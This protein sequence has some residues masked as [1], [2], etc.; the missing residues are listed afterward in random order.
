[1]DTSNP[2]HWLFLAG[3]IISALGQLTRMIEILRREANW[4]KREKERK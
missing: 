4:Q 2:W 1:M 3:L